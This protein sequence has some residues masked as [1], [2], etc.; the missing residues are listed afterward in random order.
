MHKPTISTKKNVSLQGKND[1]VQLNLDKLSTST[2]LTIIDQKIRLIE[3]NKIVVLQKNVLTNL[4]S[5]LSEA[6]VN[7]KPD[8]LTVYTKNGKVYVSLE[9]KLLFKSG[10]DMVDPKGKEAI[11]SLVQ[12]L[13]T[14]KD[15]SV[16]VEGHTDNVPIHTDEFRD[17]WELSTA[18]ATSILR[19]MTADNGFNPYKITASGRANFYPLKSNKT[20]QGR[21]GNRR[22]E[23]ILS[24]DLKD[25][26]SLLN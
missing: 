24:P 26:Y 4:K 25:V 23:I 7:Y 10:S 2:E 1:S 3:L 5:V 20:A 18:R 17:N 9:E 13:K 12:I 16:M 14:T 22:T 21:A 6:L 11:K 15:V 8:E 19:I